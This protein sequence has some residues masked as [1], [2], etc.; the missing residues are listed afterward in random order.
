MKKLL[1]I[2]SFLVVFGADASHIVG[3]DIY[4]DYLGNNNYRFTLSLYR[5]CFST[6]AAYDDPLYLAV[7]NSSGFLIQNVPITFPGSTVLPVVFNNPCVTPPT[8]ICTEVAV[9]TATI[10]LPP[11]TGGYNVSYQRCCRG[12]NI[13]NLIQPDNTGLTLTCHVPGSNTGFQVNSSPRFN[14]YPPL[15]LCN[16]EDLIFDHSATDPDGDQLV[17]S[18]VTP[19][20]GATSWNPAPNPT[21]APPYTP[22]S[23]AGGF[24]AANPLGPG[25]TINI[26]A[27]TGLLTASPNLLGLFVVGIK[28]D[29][30]R[31]GVV[32]NSTIRDFLFRVFNCNL[33]LESILPAQQDLSTF[34][35]YCSGLTVDFENNSYGGTNYSWDFGVPGITT[36]VSTAFE[37]SYTYPAPGVYQVSLVVNPGWPCTDT[38]WMEV[39]VNNEMSVEWTSQDSL[40]IFGN[41]FDFVGS[42]VGPANVEYTWDFGPNANP[43]SGTGQTVNGVEFSTTGYIPVTLYGN[44][45]YCEAEYTDSVFIFP[46]PMAD[47]ILPTNIECL[48]L[49]IDFGN[50]SQN[51]TIYGWDFG[52]QG[53]TNDVSTQE[54]P[55][56]TYP[57]PGTYTVTLVAGSTPQCKDTVQESITLN[58]PIEVSISS[59]DSLC[60][61]NNSFDFDGT[62]SGPPGTVY[63]WNFGPS[64][65]I[66]TSNDIDVSGVS[67]EG[68]GDITVTLTGTHNNCTETAV[69]N[70]YLYREPTIDF[71]LLPGLQCVPFE[72]HFIDHSWA[73]TGITYDWNFGDG[74]TSTEQ[75]PVHLYTEVGPYPVTLTISTTSGCIATLSLTNEDLVHVRPIPEAGFTLS[76]DETDI[77]HSSI[78]FFDNSVGADTYFYWFDDSTIYSTESSPNHLYLYDGHHY[79]YQ[80]VANEWGCKDTA[81]SELFIWPYTLYI[82]NTFTPDDDEFNRYFEGEAYLGVKEWNMKIYDRWGEL[83]FESNDIKYGW[84]GTYNGKIMQDGTYIYIIDLE[85]CEPLNPD[86]IVKGHVNLIR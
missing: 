59:Y 6:G 46:E 12:P 57:G 40:C 82:P 66:Q 48:G 25:A 47:M 33:Q 73:E 30:I 15:L 18:L 61:T 39:I 34:V 2:L 42:S 1:T 56:F 62:V 26:D 28:V 23:W 74:A 79:P 13:T 67:F 81:S 64:A 37:P 49:T 72:A 44:V 14:N 31:N 4:Y 11:V 10:N 55:T 20:A 52:V 16:N 63:T 45:P 19:Y 21:P 69:K 22:V 70:I 60:A 38:A 68:Y 24:S 5:D 27:N 78:G 84:D 83:L 53:T 80:V 86:K 7:Y 43:S 76:T 50:N 29:E 54:E 58:E 32:I 51:S 36:D 17:Y 65:N 77:C 71:E 8:N 75:D 3:G 41:S 85:T 35:S 9:Y